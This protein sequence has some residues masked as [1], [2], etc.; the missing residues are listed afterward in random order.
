MTSGL[1]MTLSAPERIF[2]LAVARRQQQVRSSRVQRVEQ[3]FGTDGIALLAAGLAWLTIGEL[4]AVGGIALLPLP[5]GFAV[6]YGLLILAMGFGVLTGIRITQG[7]Q[8][9]RAHRSASD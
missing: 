9:G 3:R 2:A 4:I 6:G 5:G 7:L 1:P 8:A